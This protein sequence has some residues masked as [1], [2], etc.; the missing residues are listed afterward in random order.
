MLGQ[1][2]E[3]SLSAE[4]LAR[5]FEFYRSLGFQAVTVG[6]QLEHAYVALSDGGV[7]IGLH[8]RPQE[9]PQ[10][11][12]VRPQL[13]DYARALRRAGIELE[14]AALADDEFNQL[15][16]A[17]PSGQRIALLEARTFTP[18]E[19]NNHNVR[20]C[21][22]FLE[23]SLPTHSLERSRAF[24]ETLGFAAVAQ[25]EEPQPWLRLAGR[26]LVIGLHRAGFRPGLS[27]QSEQLDA[28][29]E[30]LRAQGVHSKAGAPVAE[31]GRESATL[32]CP[33][34]SS[35]YLIEARA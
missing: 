29:L 8:A 6:D 4:P 28:R 23:Y 30:Y 15:L 14:H 22:E 35:I 3:F 7:A 25:G 33:D 9:G 34:G 24:W 20:A 12:F 18:G 26:G 31:R 16:F 11:T 27:F 32:T 1:F 10:L 21:G 2:L 13:R 17:D 5:A 19:W